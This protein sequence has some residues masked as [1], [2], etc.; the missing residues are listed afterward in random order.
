MNQQE[1]QLFRQLV[2]KVNK[3]E[4]RISVLETQESPTVA[5][6]I[7][8]GAL[9]GLPDDDHAQYALVDGTRAFTGVVTA[10]GVNLGEDTLSVFDEGTWTPAITG[11]TS[12][13]TLTYTVQSGGYW[14]FN[15]LVFYYIQIIIN[16]VSVAG[17]GDLQIS[18]PITAV[19][20]PPANVRCS[21]L[22]VPG[23]P[24]AV[25]FLPFLP[26]AYGRLVTSNDNAGAT[27]VS[28]TAIASGDQIAIA[29]F[30]GV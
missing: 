14:R 24:Y 11:S 2:E 23:T 13:P 27:V 4:R 21:G 17:T 15:N 28:V 30:Y 20:N 8:H 7:D 22:D 18:L 26:G 12:N 29:G 16:T 19:S 10:T 3:L 1:I 9:T 5:G 6:S 25:A